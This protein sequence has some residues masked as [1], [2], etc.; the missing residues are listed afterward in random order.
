MLQLIPSLCADNSISC[1]NTKFTNFGQR[2]K[3]KRFKNIAYTPAKP[4]RSKGTAVNSSNL[5]PDSK[6][7]LTNHT[8][9]INNLIS[10]VIP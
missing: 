3:V 9:G 7:I 2:G 1:L 8:L 6:I 10:R 4:N 5:F